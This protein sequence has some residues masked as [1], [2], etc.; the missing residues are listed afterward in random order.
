MAHDAESCG[1]S[2]MDE[3]ANGNVNR[4]KNICPFADRIR[5]YQFQENYKVWHQAKGE[6]KK[7]KLRGLDLLIVLCDVIGIKTE[8][9]K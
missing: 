6:D 3:W 7:P 2:K 1:I 8:G 4:N 5:D 9:V